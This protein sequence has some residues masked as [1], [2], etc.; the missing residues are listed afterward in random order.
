MKAL[1]QK[2]L[3]NIATVVV[4]LLLYGVIAILQMPRAHAAEK[5]DATRVHS[6]AVQLSAPSCA[7]PFDGA[8]P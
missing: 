3:I 4:A 1:T 6:S 5:L 2:I 8:L 7:S